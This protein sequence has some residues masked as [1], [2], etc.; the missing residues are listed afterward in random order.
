VAL[1]RPAA[2]STRQQILAC[3]AHRTHRDGVS[4]LSTRA[5][6]NEAQVNLS[7]STTTSAHARVCC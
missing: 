5:V 2:V 6:A 7:S 1:K 4:A 3:R